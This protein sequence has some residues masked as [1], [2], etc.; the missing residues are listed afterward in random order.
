MSLPF[1]KTK[2]GRTCESRVSCRTQILLLS[3]FHCA[4]LL[5][6]KETANR[7]FSVVIDARKPTTK[8]KHLG[9]IV[10]AMVC[11]QVCIVKIIL[12]SGHELSCVFTFLRR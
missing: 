2:R 1:D 5:Y 9:E 3:E 10:E 11:F 7:G 8:R 4:V 6:R 12:R